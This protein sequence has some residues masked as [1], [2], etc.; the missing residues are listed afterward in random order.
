MAADQDSPLM[1]Q[2]AT[3]NEEFKNN[4]LVIGDLHIRSYTGK[5]LHSVDG[6]RIG[7]LCLLDNKP[8]EYSSE[9]LG[10]LEDLA[11]WAEVEINSGTLSS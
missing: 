2:N 4:P 7:T 9:Q 8:R 6:F 5:S 10:L 3:L 11:K 1:V